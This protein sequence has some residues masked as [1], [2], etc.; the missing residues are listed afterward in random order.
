MPLS[1][2]RSRIHGPRFLL[3]PDPCAFHNG[4]NVLAVQGLF[5]QQG[6]GHP[7]KGVQI[8]LDELF[9]HIIGTGHDIPDLIVNLLSGQFTVIAVLGD[10]PALSK[11]SSWRSQDDTWDT[12]G[13]ESLFLASLPFAFLHFGIHSFIHILHK[14]A[15]PAL[16]FQH[17]VLPV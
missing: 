4:L 6:L 9:G 17:T 1:H 14:I 8:V 2:A 7:V 10:L 12:T 15:L 11:V 5:L 16:L 13:T 3:D